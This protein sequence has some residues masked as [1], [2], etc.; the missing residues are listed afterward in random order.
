VLWKICTFVCFEVTMEFFDLSRL[1]SSFIPVKGL[2]IYQELRS[3]GPFPDVAAEADTIIA[4]VYALP[5]W[6]I[7]ALA[8]VKVWRIL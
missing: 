4:H 8:C 2:P 3:A 5:T 7:L 6:V 1:F